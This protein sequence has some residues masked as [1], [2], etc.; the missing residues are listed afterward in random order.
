LHRYHSEAIL[1]LF[2]SIFRRLIEPRID[3]IEVRFAH[4]R[5]GD[6]SEHKRIFCS[7]LLFE[8]SRNEIKIKQEY[9]SLP[10]YSAN[11]ALLPVLERFIQGLLD[12]LYSS[13]TWVN[14]VN[15]LIGKM[16]TAEVKPGIESIAGELEISSR[17][18]QN[19]L[20]EEGT[21]FQKLLDQ[22]RK[23]MALNYLKNKDMTLLD[24]AFLLGFSE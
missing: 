14:R 18:L 12:R 19:K 24:I 2:I 15:R 6:I 23:E 9:L 20:K 5:P 8:Q 7:P 10:V 17:N 13:D 4:R 22:V 11:P 1:S 21:T 3:P 16:L